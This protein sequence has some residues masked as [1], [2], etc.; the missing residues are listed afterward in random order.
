MNIKLPLTVAIALAS[1]EAFAYPV[2]ANFSIDST[3]SN[4][5]VHAALDP[6]SDSDSH[7]LT[8]SISAVFD[9]GQSGDFRSTANMTITGAVVEPTGTYNLQLGFPPIFGVGITASDLVANIAS[10][11]PPSIISQISPNP[12]VYQF[13]AATLQVTVDQGTI[14]VTGATTDTID[15]SQEPIVGSSAPGTLGTITFTKLGT[16]G[17]YTR[18]SAALDLPI[19]IAE[20]VETEPGGP[21]VDVELTGQVRASASFYVALSPIGGDFYLDGD[22]DSQDLP[23]W[24]TGFGRTAGSIP[25]H[26]NADGDADVDGN[27]FLIWQRGL[28][29]S[30]PVAASLSS[31]AAVPEP[32]AT[33]FAA[34]AVATAFTAGRYRGRR[35]A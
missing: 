16:I 15:L 6:F 33:A 14:V 8:G 32:A 20:T 3:Q 27:D 1:P 23:A 12:A 9:F 7:S 29:T 13:D 34:L 10:L 18:V 25:P 24:R 11:S 19:S 30:P 17:P 31:V 5:A 2:T 28:G 35:Q 26:G 4:L 22:V 21:T